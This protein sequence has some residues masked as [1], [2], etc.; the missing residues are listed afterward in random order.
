MVLS[1]F[2]LVRSDCGEKFAKKIY[3]KIKR[4]NFSG[5]EGKFTTN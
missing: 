3:G 5:N 1:R 2:L 4:Q